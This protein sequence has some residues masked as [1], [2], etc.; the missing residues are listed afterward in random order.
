M[1][2]EEQVVLLHINSQCTSLDENLTRTEIEKISND[3]KLHFIHRT[4]VEIYVADYFV[5]ELT[6]G[7]NISQQI[8]DSAH[9]LTYLLTYCM[10]Q[11]PS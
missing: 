10:E 7:S 8:Q 5:K 1:F 3:G 4:F 2:A 9:L 6:K 11:S